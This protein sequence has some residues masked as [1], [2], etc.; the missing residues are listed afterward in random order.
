MHY[1]T[2]GTVIYRKQLDIE[3]WCATS[4][5]FYF[6]FLHHIFEVYIVMTPNLERKCEHMD[7]LKNKAL[8]LLHFGL[9]SQHESDF[10]FL[11]L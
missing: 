9:R 8:Y 10:V 5:H 7:H 11:W 1:I 6:N 4:H 2:F 3:S